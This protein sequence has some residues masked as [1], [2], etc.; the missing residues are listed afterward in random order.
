MM[1]SL[2]NWCILPLT[3]I[4]FSWQ[5]LIDKPKKGVDKWDQALSLFLSSNTNESTN[6]RSRLRVD[7][8][9]YFHIQQ[10]ES[11]DCGIACLLM[12]LRWLRDNLSSPEKKS[13]DEQAD[14][15]W[16][17]KTVNTESIWSID[18][19][20]VLQQIRKTKKLK[21]SY[22]FASRALEVDLHHQHLSYYEES[23]LDDQIRVTRLFQQAKE[24]DW[25]LIKL[26][27][28]LDLVQVASLVGRP[29]CLAIALVD[30]MVLMQ[31]AESSNYAGHYII[32]SGVHSD[33]ETFQIHNPDSL[34]PMDYISFPI[35]EKAWRAQGTDE[36]IIFLIAEGR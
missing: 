16:A 30:N 3:W 9:E 34:N 13:F 6:L 5:N 23:F 32:I 26:D 31:K 15:V 20:H 29:D 14:R 7:K 17:L 24:E 33:K 11:W 12:V 21:F 8:P 2:W 27:A 35:F 4:G 22:L 25:S 18:L 1:Q 19:V 10:T 28:Q 36:D